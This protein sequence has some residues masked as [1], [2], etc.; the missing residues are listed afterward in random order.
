MKFKNKFED[1]EESEFLALISELYTDP[2]PLT[3][4]ALEKYR[5]SLVL[6]FV[7]VTEHPDQ[8][9]VLFYP[10]AGADVS[11]EGVLKRVKEWRA[12]NGKPGFKN[13]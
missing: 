5:E 6:H 8:T 12:A 13:A 1:Y 10:P 2:T 7:K 11:P 4:T 9:D 3:G